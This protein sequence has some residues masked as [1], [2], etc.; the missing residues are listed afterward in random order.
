MTGN[1]KEIEVARLAN[2][3]K[4]MKTN[5]YFKKF[6]LAHDESLNKGLE[7][8]DKEC[9]REDNY[10]RDR[11]MALTNEQNV[12]RRQN[13]DAFS[14]MKNRTKSQKT[15]KEIIHSKRKL[16]SSMS[17]YK[18]N[19]TIKVNRV[20]EKDLSNYLGVVEQN[21]PLLNLVSDKELNT[22]R[23]A[24][25]GNYYLKPRNFNKKVKKMEASLSELETKFTRKN[26]NSLGPDAQIGKYSSVSSRKQSSFR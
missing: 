26:R 19:S 14:Q 25:Y 16:A 8:V 23:Q 2:T 10:F 17:P 21:D 11:F 9:Y 13:Q 20:Y 3:L 15:M 5:K 18:A 6:L 12:Y 1:Y 7:R 24:N 22:M 4:E